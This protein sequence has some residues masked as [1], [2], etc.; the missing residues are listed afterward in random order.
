M[1]ISRSSEMRE[2]ASS[3][4]QNLLGEAAVWECTDVVLLSLQKHTPMGISAQPFKSPV[5]IGCLHATRGDYSAEQDREGGP[6][7]LSTRSSQ[8]TDV[9]E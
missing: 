2:K 8:E 3:E 1:K 9:K 6:R 4:I 7:W 5:V